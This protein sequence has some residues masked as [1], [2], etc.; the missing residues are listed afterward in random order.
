MELKV[1]LTVTTDG[2]DYIWRM[3]ESLKQNVD[4][5]FHQKIIVND[6][7]TTK[8][9]IDGFDVI[10]HDGRKG[11]TQAVRTAWGAVDDD[12]DYVFHLEDDFTFNCA[13]DIH[14]M[15]QIMEGYPSLVQ[16]LLKRQAWSAEEVSAGG[17]VEMN[18]DSYE[19]KVFSIK[20]DKLIYYLTHRNFFSLNPCLIPKRVIDV[21][22]PDGNE[23]GFGGILF[24][25]QTAKAAILGTKYNKPRVHHIGGTRTHNGGYGL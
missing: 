3:L 10:N 18:P 8:L 15:T 22:W 6:E 25:D 24:S 1:A 14:S 13:I 2:R 23:A 4:F 20:E 17:F 12:V 5:P 7:G 11:L 9:S 16:M 19:Q 21:G